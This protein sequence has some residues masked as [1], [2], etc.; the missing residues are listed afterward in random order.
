MWICIYV[1]SLS[2]PNQIKNRMSWFQR[3]KW[4][5]I[6]LVT[7]QLLLFPYINRNYLS[8]KSCYFILRVIYILQK[9]FI[10]IC[11]IN[12]RLFF[13]ITKWQGFC[14]GLWNKTA[15]PFFRGSCFV[16][17]GNI[18]RKQLLRQQFEWKILF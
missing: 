16:Y 9:C 4:K 15:M 8:C 18:K 2:P 12:Y 17:L 5:Q 6:I 13:Y 7:L 1:L 11:I 14:R 3:C 10:Y